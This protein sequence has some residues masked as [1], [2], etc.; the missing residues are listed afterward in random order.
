MPAGIGPRFAWAAPVPQLCSE[1]LGSSLKAI[2]V[3]ESGFSSG[4]GTFGQGGALFGRRA[5]VGLSKS[6]VGSLSFGRQ[7]SLST[8]YIGGSYTMGNQTVAGNYAF[9]INDL[10]QLTSSR[11]NNSVKFNSANFAGFT[12]GALYGFSTALNVGLRHKF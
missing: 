8:E 1:E 6:N 5:S 3:L 10:D 11:I 4:D 12:F 2:F 7:Y 9:H